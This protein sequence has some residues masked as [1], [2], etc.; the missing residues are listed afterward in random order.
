MTRGWMGARSE[1]DLGDEDRPDYR[2]HF[3]RC[4][5]CGVWVECEDECD[6]E[7]QTI[8][9]CKEHTDGGQGPGNPSLKAPAP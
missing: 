4:E 8:V 3:H 7:I 2:T 5:L 1:F 9:R 6:D